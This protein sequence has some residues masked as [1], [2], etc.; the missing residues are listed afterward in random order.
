M[1]HFYSENIDIIYIFYSLK[2]RTNIN[3]YIIYV[4]I[5]VLSGCQLESDSLKSLLLG[6]SHARSRVTHLDLS[7]KTEVQIFSISFLFRIK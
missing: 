4:F 2:V 5:Q 1:E 6:L 7:G 3:C